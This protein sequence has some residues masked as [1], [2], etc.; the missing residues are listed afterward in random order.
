LSAGLPAIANT[1]LDFEGPLPLGLTPM[2]FWQGTPVPADAKVTDQYLS[3]GLEVSGGALIN[4]GWGHAPSGVNGLG[5]F[6]ANDLL[7]YEYPVAFLFFAP[8]DKSRPATTD[9]FAFTQDRYGDS[10]ND[11]TLTAFDL[12]GNVVG[13]SSYTEVANLASPL[14]ITGL[15]QFHSVAVHQSQYNRGTG[16]IGI[17]LVTFGDLQVADVDPNSVPEPAT[18]DLLG[19]G[20]VAIVLRS[21]SRGS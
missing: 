14:I 12:D 20:I 6:D 19:L 3:L 9:Y 1:V 5:G 16:G 11:I 8:G 17:D 13:A 7:D 10:Y 21:C 15:G 4:L 2:S 18:L